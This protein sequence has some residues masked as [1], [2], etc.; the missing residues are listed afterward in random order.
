MF[1]E[2][3]ITNKTVWVN[4]NEFRRTLTI[5]SRLSLSRMPSDP[6]GRVVRDPGAVDLSRSP[7]WE[8]IELGTL[9]QRWDEHLSG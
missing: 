3:E 1:N 7:D 2:D 5:S 6:L 8:V 4:R 9:K